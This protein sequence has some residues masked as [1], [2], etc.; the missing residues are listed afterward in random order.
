MRYAEGVR[1]RPELGEQPLSI[2]DSAVFVVPNPSPANAK[3][4]LDD[5]V[6][7]FRQLQAFRLESMMEADGEMTGEVTG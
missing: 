7:W 1:E 4:S 6:G 3:F 5:L 2:G